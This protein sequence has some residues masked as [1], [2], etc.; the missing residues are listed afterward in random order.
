VHACVADCR[1][2]G[3]GPVAL[4]ADPNDTP[5]RMY[6]ALGFRVVARRREHLRTL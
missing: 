4:T 5:R 6:T 2:R 1:A 3:A